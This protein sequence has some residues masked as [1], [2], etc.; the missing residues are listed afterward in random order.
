MNEITFQA[1]LLSV[2]SVFLL[3]SS[4]TLYFVVKKLVELWR[5]IWI[6]HCEMRGSMES[7]ATY[8]F[9]DDGN[10]DDNTT[11]STSSRGE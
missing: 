1:I 7:E 8:F 5:Q 10:A 2:L 9:G 4:I 11:V 6:S 3:M